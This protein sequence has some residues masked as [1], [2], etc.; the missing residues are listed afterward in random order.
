[1]EN[2][3]SRRHASCSGCRHKAP[4]S[5]ADTFTRRRFRPCI[6]W[7]GSSN[8]PTPS[9]IWVCCSNNN[10]IVCVYIN[11]AAVSHSLVRRVVA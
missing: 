7:M 8:P 6:F 5:V 4:V 1:M 2:G 9:M 3:G 11:N 10:A